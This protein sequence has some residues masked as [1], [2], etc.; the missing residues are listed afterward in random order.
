MMIEET[1][2]RDSGSAFN[3]IPASVIDELSSNLSMN[4]NLSPP[5]K[6]VYTIE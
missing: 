3:Q 2:L 1:I 5:K 4:S 6:E